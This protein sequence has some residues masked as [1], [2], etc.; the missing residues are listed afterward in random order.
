[1]DEQ[2]SNCEEND[3]EPTADDSA[4]MEQPI[5]SEGESEAPLAAE[6]SSETVAASSSTDVESSVRVCVLCNCVERSLHGQRE[7]RHFG[8]FSSR[9]A[10]EPSAS[11]LPGPGNDDLSSIGFSD[12]D[13]S[14]LA[15]LFDD[16]GGCW[17]HH[18]CAVWSE[19]VKQAEEAEEE[20]ENVDKAV[21]SGTQRLCEYCKRLG[22]TIRCHAEGCSRF[23]HFPCSAASG[24]F[25]SMKLLALLCPEHVDKAEEMAGEEAWCAV[26]DSAGELLNLLFCTGCGQHY[27]ASCLEISATPIQRSG[28]QCPEC[29]VC[30]TCRQ[31]GEDSMMLVCDACDKGYH[32]FCLQ[33]AMTSL[34]SDTW[35]CRRCRVCVDCGAHGLTLPGSTHWFDNYAVCEGCQRNRSS[36]CGVCSK[37]SEPPVMLPRCINCLR[38][39]HSECSSIS[40][41][42]EEKC[43]CSLCRDREPLE[44]PVTETDMVE[45]QI[46][47][48]DRSEVTIEGQTDT[49]A[50][51]TLQTEAAGEA[52]VEGQTDTLAEMTL[53][54]EA[55]GEA[56]IEG[57][58]DTLAEM[59]LQTEAAGEATIEGQTDTLAEMTLQTEAAGEV[60]IE[61][62]TDTLAEM[63]LQTEA[64]G[65]ATIEGQADVSKMTGVQTKTKSDEEVP[66]ELGTGAEVVET[67]GVEEGHQ[68][69][70]EEVPAEQPMGQAE[71]IEQCETTEQEASS[72]PVDE[73]PEKAPSPPP[74]PQASHVLESPESPEPQPPQWPEPAAVVELGPVHRKEKNG[75][76]QGVKPLTQQQTKLEEKRSSE[77][78][79]TTSPESPAPP[80]STQEVEHVSVDTDDVGRKEEAARNP[81]QERSGSPAPCADTQEAVPTVDMEVRATHSEEE[82]EFG[83][84]EEQ[85]KD[86]D[87][88]GHHSHPRRVKIKQE[89]QEQRKPDQL[90]LDEMSN[91]SHPSHGDESSSGFLGSPT[92]G[93][94]EPDA[95]LS[96]ELSL[97]PT[98]RS[99][100]DSLLTETD[101]S[102]PFDPL[103]PDGEKK[104]R[105]SPGR[106]RVKQGR[107]SSSFPGKR[108]P[109]GGGGGGGGGGRGR[110]GR[111]RLK[112]MA[113]CIDAF[114][115]SMTA[116]DTGL[117][118]EEEQG[119][120]DEAMQNTVVLFSNTDKFVLL[121]DMCVVCGSFGKGVEGQL[122]ACAQC[123][124]CYHPYCVNSKMTKMMLRK[125]WRCLECIVCEVCGKASDPARL[126]LCDDCDVSYHTYCLD[127]PL[128]TVPKGGWKCKWCV[129]CMQC[130]ASSPGFHCE[131][132]NNYT[133]CGPCASLVTCPVCRENFMEEELLLQCQ[134]CDRW[135]HA[136]CESLYTEDEVEQA[137]DE[138][139]ACTS[140]TP[141]VP[142]PI[143]TV[144]ST[145]MTAM[146]IKEPEPQFYRLEGV[147]LT[148][149][150]MSLLRR[151]SMSP[152]HKR[153]QR[154][155]RLGML[156]GDGGPDSME[157]KDGDGDEG[158]GC[159]EP[160]EC[161]PGV[162][163]VKQEPSGSPY[164]ELG[165]EGG[166]EG[167]EEGLKGV[168]ETDEGKKRKRKPYRPGIGGFMVR[169]R[170][171][172]TR[173]KKGLFPH[174]SHLAGD[175]TVTTAR[176]TREKPALEEG[177]HP[178][179]P[180]DG[181]PETKPAEGEGEQAKKRRGRKKSK[182]ED[183][184]PAYL[185]E[186][187]FG[188]QLMD[189]SKKALLVTP[190]QRHHGAM[191]LLRP[192]L[193][194]AQGARPTA[195]DTV[196][197]RERAMGAGMHLK[198][199][200]GEGS[201]AQ[202]EGSVL[203][204]AVKDQGSTDPQGSEKEKNEGLPEGMESQ[205]SEQFFRKVLG[206]SEGVSL[207]GS[208]QSSMRPI[209]EGGKGDMNCS[210]LPQR[211]LLTVSLPSAGMMDSFPGLSQSPFFDMRER[212]GLFS[213]DGGEESPWANPSTPATPS[214]PPTPTEADGDGLSYNQRSLQRWEKDEE[215]GEMST[216][217]P[218]LYANTNF[219]TLRRDYP[220]WSSRCKQIMKI[221]RK[222]SAA[223]KVPFLQKAK[224]NRA[225]QRINK[226][227]KQAESQVC[228]PIKTEGGG[229][230]RV[231]GERPNL[232]LQ[233]PPPS[234]SVSTSS[235]P[236]SAESPF[237][238]HPDSG[239][240]STFFPDG[241]V[242]TPGSASA[243]MR[244]DPFAKLPPQSPHPSTLYS[245]H[246]AAS[247]PMQG[248]ASSSGYP[249]PGPQA[250]QGHPAS[251]GPF[252]MQPGNP[253]RAQQVDPF[254]RPQQQQIQGHLSQS[255]QGSQ[256]H[257]G[258][259]ESPR[260]RGGGPGDSP[261][262]SPPHTTHYGDPF[263]GQQQGMG[264]PEY[265][266]S[267]SQV[268]S[269]SGMGHGQYRTDM[270]G[271]PSPR[272]SSTGRQDLSNTGS[273]AGMLDSGDGLF[274]APMTPR[275]HQ[276]ES[277]VV[278]HPGASP[279]HPSEGYR[280]STSTPFQ[281]PYAQPPLT[282]RPQSG[283]SCSP[284]PQQR[285]PQT[286][287]ESCPRVPSSPQSQGSSLSPLTPG[288]PSND[289]FSVQSPASTSRFQSPDPYSRPP[290]RP[291]S[292][293]PFA[294]LHKPPRPTSAAPEGTPSFRGSPHPNQP[295]SLPPSSTPVGDPLSGKPSGPH[296]FSRGPNIAYQMAQQQQQQQLLQQH[297]QQLLQQQQQLQQQQ[298]QTIGADF[299]SRMPLQQNPTAPRPPE[300]PHPLGAMPGAQ[301]MPDMSAVQDPSLLGLSP[302]ELEKHRQRQKL[303]EFLIRQQMQR[304]SIRQEKEAAATSSAATGWP[305]GDMAAYQQD[306][307]HRAPPP[308]PQDRAV[309]A[310]G[311]QASLAG[312]M[313]HAVVPMDVG[314]PPPPGTPAMMDP[315]QLRQPG[316][317]NPQ[318]MYGRPQFPGQWQQGPGPRRFPQPGMEGVG[319]SHHLNA[320]LNIQ[321]AM[322]QGMANPRGLVPCPG[323]EPMQ[324]SMDPGGPPPQ[325]IEL[326]HNSQ[327]LPLGPQQRPP[328]YIPQQQEMAPSQFVQHPVP[329]G[330][331]P[332]TEGVRDS[333]L[334]LQQG[335][336]GLLMP[337]QSTGSSQQQQQQQQQQPHLQSQTG[338]PQTPNTLSSHSGQQHQ[339][340]TE[341]Q[342]GVPGESSVDL[343]EPDLEDPFAPK[344]LGDAPGDGGVEDEDDLALDLDPDK[345]DDDLGNLDNLETTDPHLDD[346]LNSDEFDLLAYTDPELDQGDP[347]DV[348][349]DQ[350][351]LVEA[352]GETP[353]TSGAQDNQVEQKPKVEQN[354]T[355]NTGGSMN[356]STLHPSSSESAVT[357]RI[358]LEPGQAVV[359]DEMGDAV[360]MLLQTNKPSIQPDNQGASLSSVRL[361]GLPYPLPGQADS[362]SSLG[363]DPLA[364]P[365]GGGQ[366]SPAVDLDK[367]ESSLEASELPLLI[368]DLL[369]HEKKE[370]QKQQQQQQQQLS[371]LHQGAM[372]GHMG[373]H[374]NP[375]G[376]P[377]HI[378]LPQ[379][380]R[381]PPQSMMGLPGMVP[382]PPHLLQQQRLVGQPGITP[383]HM[384]AMAQQQG[385]MR[386][387]QPGG[388][389][390]GLNPQPQQIVKQSALANNFF[391]DKDLDKFV[392]D[393]IMDPIA[394]AKMVALKGIKRVLAQDP[395][396]VPSGINRQQVSLLAQRL[397]SAP[398]TGDPQ[399]QL[400]SG[401]SKEG[402]CS[403]PTQSRPNPPQ[404]VQG[405]INDAEQHQYE[406][407]L[408]HTQQLLQMQLKFL[409]EQIG[410]HRKS[411]KA[412]CAKQR[413]AKKAGREFAEA[414]AEKL[415]LV[416]E[417]QSKIQKQLD[418]VRKQQKEHT[419]LIAEYRSK[420]QQHQQC[421]GLLAPGPST[422]GPH[423][424]SKMPGQMMGQ[425]GTPVIS[426]PPGIMPQGGMPVRM[427]PQ[428]QPFLGGG[429]HLGTLGVRPPGPPGG[430]PAAFFPQGPGGVQGADP[431]LLQERQHRMQIIQKLQQQQQQQA[432]MQGQQ[433]M[434]HPGGQAGMLPQS[435][436]GIM[437]NPLMGQQPNLQQGMMP[438]QAM[439]PQIT[440]PGQAV[441][442]PPQT[443]M[444]GQP[445]NQPLGMTGAQT[446][447]QQQQRPQLMM[448]EQGV[449]GP[450]QLH[451]LRG[452][453]QTQLTPQQQ[454]IL[455]QRMLAQQQLKLQQ[456]QQVAQQQL[457]Q[458]PPQG[459]ISQPNQ[460][461]DS[462][463][464]LSQPATPG[465]MGS[466]PA[467][468]GGSTRV[469]PQPAEVLQQGE[470]GILSPISRTPPQQGGPGP[471]IP[472]QMTQP[473]ASGEQQAAVGQQQQYM[474]QQ[475]QPALQQQQPPQNTQAGLQQQAGYQ[476]V[477]MHPQGQQQ[478]PQQQQQLHQQTS[479]QRQSS[480]NADPS[481][482]GL[483]TVK[484]EGQQMCFMA[485]R[486]QQLQQHNLM[487][488]A[489]DPI[490]QQQ[491]QQHDSMGQ[492]QNVIGQQNHPG[493][494][495]PVPGMPGH[496]SPQ[497]Q[498]LMAQQAQQQKQQAMMGMLRTQQQVIMPGQRP[499][500]PPGQIRTP[501]N[502]QAIIAQNPQLRHLTPN[503]QIQH[504]QAMIQ[505]RQLQLQQQQQ[506]QMMRLQVCQGQS[507]QMRPQGPPGLGQQ[508]GQIQRMPGGLEAQQMHY[509]GAMGKPRG[510]GSTQQPG[511]IAP[512]QPP[513][514]VTPQLQQQGIMGPVVQ[515]QQ[516]G[517]SPQYA[518]SVQQQ[519]MMQ[520]QAQQHQMRGQLP[521]TRS[522]MGQVRGG[523]PQ[524]C[525]IRPVSPRQPLANSSGDPQRHA[526][527]QG[528]GMRQPNPNQVMQHQQQQLHMAQKRFQ[529]SPSHAGSPAGSSVQKPEAGMSPAT[530]GTPHSTHV[531]S[532]SVTDGAAGK[533]SPYSQSKPSPL[534]SPGA[535]KSPLDY[536]GLKAESG[537][538]TQSQVPPNRLSPQKGENG[539]QQHPQQGSVNQGG[540]QP[541]PGSREGTLCKMTLQNIKQE[542]RELTC[543]GEGSSGPHSGAI[544]RE[545]T[546]EP[547]GGFGNNGPGLGGDPG[548]HV[549]RTETGQQLLQK[550]LRTKNLQLAAQRPSEGIHNEINGHI[551]SKLAMLEQKLQ[552]TPRNMEDLQSITKRA[553]VAKAKRSNK[554]GERAPQSRKKKKEE[555][556]KS[557]EALMKQLKQGLSLL[558]LMEPSITASLDLF[559]PFGSSPANGKAQLK[560]SFGN[561]LLGNIPDYYSQLLTKS[562]LSNP[563]TPP[564]SLPPTPPPSV[565]HKL[566]N[567]ATAVE[568]LT[569]E[570]ETED[571]MDSVTEEVKSVDIL[572]ALPTPPHNQNED[573][574]MESD[575][576]SDAPDSIVPA[577]SP[578]CDLGDEALRFP[579]FREP[580]EEEMERTISP[581][582]PLIP[583]TAI[584]VFPEKP[585]EAADG[586]A[587][588]TTNPWD[589][590]KSNEVAV[591][592]TLSSAAAKNLNHVMVVVAQLLH[593]RMPGSYEV[594]FSPS[595]GRAGASGPGKE[596]VQPG[597][598]CVKTGGI[599]GSSPSQNAEWLRQFDISL[600]GCTL[601]KQVDIL[602]LIKQELPE[603]ED[604]PVQHCYTT[605]V[606][607]LDVRHLP[608][609]PVED[610]PPSSPS[611]PPPAPALTSE[612]ETEPPTQPASP[613]TTQPASPSQAP[614]SPAQ[615]TIQVKTEPATTPIQI[616]IEPDT[617]AILPPP[618]ASA[619]ADYDAKPADQP[620]PQDIPSSPTP[621]LEVTSPKV[622]HR[623]RPLSPDPEE[624]V[625]RPK[626]K[627][628]K[629]LRWK[630]LQIVITIRKGGS[631]K[632]SSRGVSELMER[633]RITLRPDKLPRDKRKCC[634]CHE[635][636]D[637]AT[638]GPA[639]LL[640]IDV[641][642][643]VHL[644]CALWSTEVYETQGGAL[645]NVEMALRRGLRTRCACC[646]KTGATNSCNRLR[647]PNV[648]HFTC[649]IRARCMFFRD[650][651]MLCTQHKL[652]GPSEE[653]LTGFAVFR[654]VYI[655]RDEVKQ[656]A[657]ILQRGDRIHLFRVGG[658]IFHAVGQLL[659]SQMQA[660]HSPTAIFPV[661]FEATR[662]YWSTRVPNRRCRYRCRI[663]E[664]EGRPMFEVRVL[665]HGQ[666]DLHYR[667]TSPEGIWD[668]VV[669][670]VAKL[671]EESAMLK[672]FTDHVK[673][674]EMYGLTVHAVLRI[675]ESLP[676][677]ENCQNYVFR[678]GRHPLMELPLMINPTGCARSEPKIL[679]HC[680]SSVSLSLRPHTLNSTSMS[681]AYQS[682]FTGEINTPYS[683]Q[684]VHSKSSQYRRLKTEWKNNVYLARSQIQGLGLYA[685]KDLDKHTMVIEYIGT[686]I[687]NEVANRRE[688]IYEEQNRGIYMFRTNN[689]HVI[690]ATLTGGPARYVNHSC[691]PNCVAEVVTF[692]KEDKI[693]II[694]SRRIPKGEE[695]T[696]DYQFDFEDDQHKIP[697]HCGA[698]NCRKWMN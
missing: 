258:P 325:F 686:I 223:D 496:P 501:V 655:E 454:Q 404:F 491:Q 30:Q 34:P 135:V 47:E 582:I 26:C 451:G 1:M 301:E 272:S 16:T 647:C 250:P 330:M 202:V 11:S 489:Q 194:H 674:E 511:M 480:L 555:I 133:H 367:V 226:A 460:S 541:P 559:A 696:Y 181:A 610:S 6:D 91:Q 299:H 189:L 289:A 433:P 169:Q 246:Q 235:Q 443:L 78:M 527:T 395:M 453:G 621:S 548:P 132:Q 423:S 622:K 542:P 513:G 199:E 136:V 103:K 241:P 55:A 339:T 256:E 37:A 467:S 314:C 398:G 373:G 13:A 204:S 279:N 587:V 391:P 228:R 38:W 137:S 385:V 353:G 316:P 525:Q 152:L 549:P 218:V 413:T 200:G 116:A 185:Q 547:V 337:Q 442:Q 106:S 249:H 333:R 177:P 361:G 571:T 296:G 426:Q 529:G 161:E 211:S 354:P 596:P 589:K 9:P 577:S 359:K 315:N 533:R 483:V 623:S 190:G 360:S 494:P 257:L 307:A 69:G 653:E 402:E 512:S 232:H 269:P 168:E 661:G 193:P 646:Q 203:S 329:Q 598:L 266:S 126:L 113:S 101:D 456:Q 476:Q 470:G 170:K 8:P 25:Q 49:L 183:M 594:A 54:T 424:L 448:G 19:G 32:T 293:D 71:V 248:Q 435:Q 377:G 207:G 384:A 593:I 305:G 292:R 673:A 697:C 96:M 35:K 440:V 568:E 260:S 654:R 327:R 604:K 281:D 676:G 430:P 294:A 97:I 323:G 668:R 382:R 73:R 403:D 595:P 122:L 684:F 606:S 414:D 2:K 474:A 98:E 574:R 334:G 163:G 629:G 52:T 57:Q 573:I 270:S 102:L 280:Q 118:K 652:K 312:K 56:T 284:L 66:M 41:P 192:P 493:Q 85:G 546:G 392:T 15:A 277:G 332:Q 417:E 560:G 665:E 576:D 68:L 478:Q 624:M 565:Q 585:F 667:D 230:V 67:T 174:L 274:K 62:Q 608:V 215:L 528:L 466:S 408:L 438:N 390:P 609:I 81:K 614:S 167:M 90:L 109:R 631:K 287:Q 286:Q 346:L 23:Y 108:R 238:F 564:S 472:G 471:S 381:P 690:D 302:S 444:G 72:L 12:S 119:E 262:F 318:G 140:C 428:G 201:Q 205:D 509:G 387:G 144:D 355:P 590:D 288:A 650:K 530:P 586:K 31:P 212:G 341:T 268:S 93:E 421:S 255:Q 358:K 556:G 581:T 105:G 278:L 459:F 520:Q 264:R 320:P 411:R 561:A 143:V 449:V 393:D 240:S 378:M 259:P 406:E 618:D 243:D 304:N 473:G 99:R 70:T 627:K 517:A 239:S 219:P 420:Q 251:L 584:P 217:S 379:H 522:P 638:D 418:Q 633:L 20:L 370:L 366:H 405:I 326:R 213:P 306:K 83:E 506:G 639:R 134:H 128:H 150:G 536:P 602:S 84:L 386:V 550:L 220:D 21:I 481:K 688:K 374:P 516:P 616:K 236:S 434:P 48:K 538:T 252:D 364:L 465:Q 7:L 362:L 540:P 276:G 237:P 409:E 649:G 591:T 368:Q 457:I 615:T 107:G 17:V 319:P 209:L 510:L 625:V 263:R 245:S 196:E 634:F 208:L 698:W 682:T 487:Q 630:R 127:P 376:G 40:E 485:Q 51:M 671:R 436:S 567:G 628:W 659:P 125:G 148:E 535:S 311:S 291:Q 345:G 155:S 566:L 198:Q 554:P 441:P 371:S 317:P 365:D 28:W 657:S 410:A 544:K 479:L 10:L 171:C 389:H 575:E 242:K 18:W 492:M 115:L 539:L 660:F 139:F 508:V 645:M 347:K 636:G 672:L 46:T 89:P 514:V 532:P 515:Q 147:W 165:A 605:N 234:G 340:S 186:A 3:S 65:E 50:E 295:P 692:D 643:W 141:Y 505:Q 562:N 545:V 579:R 179:T 86:A 328:L 146:K 298:T 162:S 94:A 600:P 552:G 592:F 324:Q 419:N 197:V 648:Y 5:P 121:Q 157:L 663:S 254:F 33:P 27:H 151:I 172:H 60:T 495:Q 388:I 679:T 156:C 519:Q 336:M 343:P 597:A 445:M 138:G 475:Q 689:E 644:N 92:E 110:G 431:R 222:I 486:Q 641:D 210:S 265:A 231:K 114:L 499:G 335:N 461:Q 124:Q 61:G 100:S 39:V 563:P 429:Q 531:A 225:A 432:M 363:E 572:A 518:L 44:D 439:L 678:Y 447:I 112:A 338:T 267:P 166:A 558:P 490:G 500:V 670:S 59:T 484:Q 613:S 372:G 583:R 601:K 693:I 526:M 129:S 463:G 309:T 36:M 664:T 464:G 452:P 195:P 300:A 342:A 24:S 29:K 14:C 637:G 175:G 221:W 104:R 275:M 521:M 87:R 401:P 43:I 227:Q 348:F 626:V 640:N 642:L 351:R 681:K 656:I 524:G 145:Y 229:G 290:S 120:E 687:R 273:P 580:K 570:Q 658:L 149:T 123:A 153:R 322:Q 349:S 164:R 182:L 184:F 553:P 191:G 523:P 283:D 507:G 58:T 356:S 375:Q 482:S 425:Q 45:M 427:P 588:S 455:A 416:T 188:K 551:N 22:A 158:K 142:K 117:S 111:N 88:E 612:P 224:D 178:D 651:T 247:S 611:P 675:T 694:S 680:K 543:D 154:R 74:Q 344:G 607:D 331:D 79:S 450:P 557:T 534:R 635:E 369:E 662:I 599:E 303:R 244:T 603:Q 187:F 400:A 253:R 233:I 63:T 446:G 504:I 683:K 131:W 415:K 412:L 669:Q 685:A 42:P 462:Q 352:E 159:G 695:L 399:G 397:A 82:E 80:I 308:Y 488:Q 620:A 216:I 396:G 477:G 617:E 313:P 130:G 271:G 468:A 176:P 422:Q 53:Q 380:H 569:E 469:T 383:Q 214:T 619:E 64:A 310:A 350:L 407:W 394:K 261:L 458:P 666:E 677:V 503:Q 321:Q 578:E 173:M 282:P 95:Q 691:A 4:P 297:Q 537:D 76:N 502:I 180:T 498:A 357:S 497:Q 632:E 285:H 206:S 75:E 77:G 437:G 160:M